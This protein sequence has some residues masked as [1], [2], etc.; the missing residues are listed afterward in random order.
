MERVDA[1]WAP[2]RRDLRVEAISGGGFTHR[3]PIHI[4]GWWG[5]AQFPV[6]PGP[7]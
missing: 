2:S 3:S 1:A 6:L 4:Q 5:R 7:I